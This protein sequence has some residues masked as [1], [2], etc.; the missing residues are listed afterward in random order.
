MLKH[1]FITGIRN[2]LKHRFFSLLNIVGLS[3]GVA[4]FLILMNYV[5]YEFSYDSYLPDSENIYRVDYYAYQGNELTEQNART[6]T[7]L[8]SRIKQDMPE[9]QYVARAY[10]ENC[11]LFNNKAKGHQKGFWADS[12]FLN[13]FEVKML[14]GDR[15]KCLAA[16]RSMVISRSLANLYFGKEDP[17]GK[18]INLNE[19][20]HFMVTGVFED[21]PENASVRFNFLTSWSTMELFQWAPK[22]GDFYGAWAST[23]VKLKPGAKDI[24]KI[25][26]HLKKIAT[27]NVVSLREKNMK[28]KYELRPLKEI[29]FTQGMMGEPVPGRSKTILYAL[30]GVAIFILIA[31]WINYINLSLA[32]SFQRAEEIMVRK[33]YGASISNISNQFITEAFIISGIT[34]LTGFGFYY[35]FVN[36]LSAYL[37]PSFYKS[38]S[39]NQK[40]LGYFGFIILITIAVAVFPSRIIA[41]YN[42]AFIL[43]RQ[44]NN[45]SNKNILKNGLIAFQMLLSIFTIGCTLIASRQINYMQRFNLGFDASHTISLAG[46]VSRNIDSLR[47]NR[48][49]AFRD[50]LLKDN[51]FIAGTASMNIPGEELRFHDESIRL[52]GSSN[53]KKQTFW[54]S[55]T[56]DGFIKT[57]GLKL[58]A[59]RNIEKRDWG[60]NCLINESAAKALGFTNPAKAVN[61]EFIKSDNKRQRIVGVVQDF[62][63]ESL[64]KKIEPVIFNFDHPFEFGY[65]TFRINSHNREAAMD[66]LQQVWKKHYPDD[67]FVFYF[68]DTFFAKQYQDEIA[69]SKLLNLFSLMSIVV[70]ALGLFGLASLSVVKRTKEIG[71]RKVVGAS[72]FRILVLLSKDYVKLVVIAFAIALPLF[73]YIINQ[74]LEMFSYKIELH[75]WMFL[76]PGL[77]VL[78]IACTIVSIQSLRA[79]LTN[80]VKS[81]RTE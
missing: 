21:V 49:C 63:H 2:L 1:Y 42:P 24:S 69:F 66:Q 37:S 73:Y 31:A 34:V 15:E 72:V 55:N 61:A 77:L 22:G 23:Y 16:P 12:S 51:N 74:W 18:D 80:P 50:E 40:W 67:P 44:Y 30:I 71:I 4:T 43:K 46:P 3:I 52:S 8:S 59:G 36:G 75:W 57:F 38:Q 19:H 32:Q 64:K 27:D 70:A 56:D 11:L 6:H 39:L 10:N 62:H 68:M 9:V 28:G 26:K 7:G 20:I 17:M 65:Y 48:F 33:V 78:L 53:E 58:L 79:A 29:H 60:I 13:V 47:Y 81:L 25:N 14:Q 5:N 45:G 76:L 35:L 41:K 54:V